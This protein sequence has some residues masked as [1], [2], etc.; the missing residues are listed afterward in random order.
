MKENL[1]SALKT[2]KKRIDN[3]YELLSLWNR[4]TYVIY[5]S[6]S[7]VNMMN[8]LDTLNIQPEELAYKNKMRE[9]DV[10]KR[11]NMLFGQGG[12]INEDEAA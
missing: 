2:I 12:E 4:Y 1:P 6:D 8:M 10:A 5:M 7:E 9:S 11:L 3:I